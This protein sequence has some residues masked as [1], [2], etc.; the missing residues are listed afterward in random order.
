MRFQPVLI[1]FVGRQISKRLVGP[2]HVLAHPLG[3]DASLGPHPAVDVEA[4]L[5]NA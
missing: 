1:I 2:D 4:A 5:K 3:L